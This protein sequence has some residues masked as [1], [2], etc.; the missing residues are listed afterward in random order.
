[1]Q[2]PY[3]EYFFDLIERAEGSAAND[4]AQVLEALPFQ[5]MGVNPQPGEI[6]AYDAPHHGIT[7]M[8]DS[9][10]HA[11]GRIW[12]PTDVPVM[13]DG[14]AWFTHEIQVIA[15]GPTSGT[16][17][18]AWQDKGG[19]PVRP[20]VADSTPQPPVEPVPQ[21]EPDDDYEERISALE[22]QVNV[23]TAQM[24]AFIPRMESVEQK[25]ALA[26]KRG[27]P[28]SVTGRVSGADIAL[29]RDLTWN[30]NIK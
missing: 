7:V 11:R 13:H 25:V 10:G 9:G 8:I 15:D 17:V 4:W 27:D 20:F 12:L 28:V 24:L 22:E 19:A 16:F 14:N 29:R 23:L 2:Q 5:G 1:M 3:R 21:P 6:Q 30:G 26:A 18:W